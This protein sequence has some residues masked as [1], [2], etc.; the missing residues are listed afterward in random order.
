MHNLDYLAP[1]I[2]GLACIVGFIS[3]IVIGFISVLELR[4]K[5]EQYRKRIS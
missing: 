2:F 3:G 5:Y 4:K 1:F